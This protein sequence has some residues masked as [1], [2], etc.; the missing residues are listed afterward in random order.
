VVG[1]KTPGT[2]VLVVS[3][4]CDREIDVGGLGRLHFEA[5]WYLYVGSALGGLW[6]RIGRH[7]RRHKRLHWHIDHLLRYGT[8]V[9]IWYCESSERLECVW[10]RVLADLPGVKPFWAAFGATDCSC[11]THLFY[12]EAKPEVEGFRSLLPEGTVR[13]HQ[14]RILSDDSICVESRCREHI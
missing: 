1:N 3:L 7:L 12:S 4:P 14:R 13:V 5:G 11:R 6:A 8:V 2:Y 10:A 9:E